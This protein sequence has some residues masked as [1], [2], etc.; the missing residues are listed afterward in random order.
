[1]RSIIIRL[2][3]ILP[4]LII[5]ITGH[6]YYNE[7]GLPVG[8]A[9]TQDGKGMILEIILRLKSKEYYLVAIVVINTIKFDIVS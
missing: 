6:F 7:I 8:K 4:S 9:A 2:H 5:L 3:L 1:M